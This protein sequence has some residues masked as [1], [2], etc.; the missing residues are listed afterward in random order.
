MIFERWTEIA[1]FFRFGLRSVHLEAVLP[2]A[3]LV[4]LAE[5]FG[6]LL[7]TVTG[8]IVL[9]VSPAHNQSPLVIVG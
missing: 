8:L 7:A 9:A 5:G 1:L 4:I 3:V 2:A 6:G